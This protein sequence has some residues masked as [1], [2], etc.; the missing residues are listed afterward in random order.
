M[1][2]AAYEFFKNHA[3]DIYYLTGLNEEYI[4]TFPIKKT[5]T[6]KLNYKITLHD[7]LCAYGF[8]YKQSSMSNVSFE[9]TRTIF[10]RFCNENL[11]L[12]SDAIK[13]IHSRRVK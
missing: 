7:Y 10:N 11:D 6:F 12:Y 13:F 3:A 4:K 5:N 9:T 2:L 1:S 8:D